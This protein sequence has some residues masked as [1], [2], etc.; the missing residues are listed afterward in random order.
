MV[1]KVLVESQISDSIEL[2]RR[3][4]AQG[5]APSAA[6]WQYVS[7]AAEWRFLIAGSTFDALLPNNELLAYGKIVDALAQPS[8]LPSLT[9][10]DVQV[11][12]TDLPL[13]KL[14]PLLIQTGPQGLARAYFTNM[15]LNSI[16]VEA[17]CIIRAS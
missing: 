9:I 15:K 7:D 16:F 4:D 12:K 11:A 8:L 2:A 6:V 5:D 10:A 13:L 1:E 14:I 3:L 17:M